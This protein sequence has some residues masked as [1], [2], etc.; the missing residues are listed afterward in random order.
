M[1]QLQMALDVP[2]ARNA[3][4]LPSHL[5]AHEI[6]YSGLRQSQH[7]QIL[8]LVTNRPRYTSLELAQVSGIDRHTIALRLPELERVGLV[9][10]AG[11]RQCLVGHRLATTWELA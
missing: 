2:I 9:R 3:D 4:P 7:G 6:T 1:E 5:A 8:Q 11:R 10:K